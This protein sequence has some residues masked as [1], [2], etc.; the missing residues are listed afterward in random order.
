MQKMAFALQALESPLSILFIFFKKNSLFSPKSPILCHPPYLCSW[1]STPPFT[2]PPPPPLFPHDVPPARPCL[3]HLSRTN[4]TEKA[5][6]FAYSW[7]S[8][9]TNTTSLGVA[10]R[11]YCVSEYYKL[12]ITSQKYKNTSISSSVQ[13]G[14]HSN[15]NLTWNNLTTTGSTKLNILTNINEMQVNLN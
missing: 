5:K 10:Q 9:F 2:A 8:I 4:S 7:R 1:M 13:W 3:P 14:I 6:T 12:I 15:S 11:K